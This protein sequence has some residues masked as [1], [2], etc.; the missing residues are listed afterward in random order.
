MDKNLSKKLD[1]II[2][3][4]LEFRPIRKINLLEGGLSKSRNYKIILEDGRNLFVKIFPISY[5]NRIKKEEIALR[6]LKNTE[7]PAPKL[8]YINYEFNN[9]EG[10]LIQEYIEG[11]SLKNILKKGSFNKRTLEESGKFLAKLHKYSFMGEWQDPKSKIKSK[12]EWIKEKVKKRNNSNIENLK[13]LEILSAEKIRRMEKYIDNFEKELNSYDFKL[14]PLH[15]DYNLENIMINEG[16][17]KGIL[18][19]E[20]HHMGHNLSDLGIAYYWFKF[21]GF[22]R[23]FNFFLEGYKKEFAVK[24][25]ITRFLHGYYIMQVIGAISFLSKEKSS[26][27]PLEILKD[28]LSEFV[29]IVIKE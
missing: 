2:R 20:Q 24:M 16:K 27:K 29:S 11:R 12:E 7:I 26:E 14:C 4:N 28:M 19:F 15:G 3:E 9:G 13:K 8:F 25:D 5:E 22:E 23:L 21:E 18:D 17:V 1:K 6:L 10:V